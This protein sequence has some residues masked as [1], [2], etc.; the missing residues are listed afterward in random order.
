MVILLPPVRMIRI[1]FPKCLIIRK[2]VSSVQHLH[3]AS[4]KK[5]IQRKK[6]VEGL[7]LGRI[8]RYINTY[9]NKFILGLYNFTEQD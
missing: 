1:C 2:C 4:D 5:S 7:V 6:H 9:M 3:D 8:V